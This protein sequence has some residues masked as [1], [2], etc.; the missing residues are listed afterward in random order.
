MSQDN[1]PPSLEH[2]FRTEIAALYE[3]SRGDTTSIE[4][5]FQA[6]FSPEAVVKLNHAP[7]SLEEMQKNLDEARSAAVSATLEWKDLIEVDLDKVN[8]SQLS[9]S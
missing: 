6:V 9:A 4:Q 3:T 8:K 5:R 2:W 7:L 1:N